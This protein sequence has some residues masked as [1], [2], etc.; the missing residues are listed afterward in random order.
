MTESERARDALSAI[1][2]SCDREQWVRTGMAAKAAGLSLDDW[3]EWSRGGDNFRSARDCESVWD[4]V[5]PGAVTAGTL[6]Y[7][8]R[9]HGWSESNKQR[10]APRAFPSAQTSHRPARPQS[11]ADTAERSPTAFWEIC[12]PATDAHPYI[13]A[14]GGSA[15]GLRVVPDNSTE[16]IAGHSVAGWLVVPV[17]SPAGELQTLQLIPPPGTGA[18]LN[19]PGTAFDDSFHVVGAVD[20]SAPAFIVEGIGQAWA[21]WKATGAAAVVSFG[22]GRMGTV[23]DAL[24]R[25]HPTTQ[26]VLVPDRGKEELAQT[27][28][29]RTQ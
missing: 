21:C 15:D 24:R 3:T 4:S 26:L 9:S 2:P 22:A 20:P 18:K 10:H 1:D 12:R 7:M 28:A 23:S 5:K 11:P 13:A 6:F 16:R 14:K 29:Q 25:Q 8:A 17:R 19:W 27:I